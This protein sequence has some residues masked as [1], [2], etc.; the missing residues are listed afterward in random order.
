MVGLLDLWVAT[1]LVGGNSGRVGVHG[2][3]GVC[4][5]LGALQSLRPGFDASLRK[6]KN[7]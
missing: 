4:V 7:G 2:V 1:E 3:V 6:G 5:A